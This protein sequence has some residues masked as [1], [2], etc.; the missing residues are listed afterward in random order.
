MPYKMLVSLRDER[1]K[2]L[3]EENKQMDKDMQM[4]D[5]KMK[6]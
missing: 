6:Q 4:Q 2:R 5:R 1:M 3:T